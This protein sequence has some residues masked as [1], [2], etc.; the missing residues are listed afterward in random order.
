MMTRLETGDAE[1]HEIDMLQ[2]VYEGLVAWD[3]NNQNDHALIKVELELVKWPEEQTI[4][5]SRMEVTQKS[6]RNA[7]RSLEAQ[8]LMLKDDFN[9]NIPANTLY[10]QLL[11]PQRVARNYYSNEFKTPISGIPNSIDYQ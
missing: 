5:D 8:E 11:K 1:L 2:Q 3:E 9:F 7:A 6:I 10:Q 4:F